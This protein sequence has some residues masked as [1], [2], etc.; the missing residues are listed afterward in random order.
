[1]VEELA[2]SLST[3]DQKIQSSN[4][5]RELLHLEVWRGNLSDSRERAAIVEIMR[6]LLSIRELE[7]ERHTL[8]ARH[9]REALR[10]QELLGS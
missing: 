4:W 10:S 9:F 3:I 7:K 2:E 5:E 6:C 1:M 8:A